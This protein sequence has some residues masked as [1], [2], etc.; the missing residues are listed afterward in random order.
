MVNATVWVFDSRLLLPGHGPLCVAG[1]R[2]KGSL[3]S[4]GGA[5]SAGTQVQPNLTQP[6]KLAC[7]KLASHTW[8]PQ[9]MST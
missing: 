6:T 2:G 1:T 4:P 7:T 8:M 3:A 5:S 9:V